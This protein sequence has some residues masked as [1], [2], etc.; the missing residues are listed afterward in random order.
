MNHQ[1]IDKNGKARYLN[2]N[3]LENLRRG[4]E[5][6]D[7]GKVRRNYTLL[8]ETV[9]WLKEQRNASDAIDRLVTRERQMN[10]IGGGRHLAGDD[11]DA[12]AAAV[13]DDPTVTRNGKDKGAVKRAIE[14]LLARLR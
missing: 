3:S 11:L 8:P 14:A 5:A 4:S 6:R 10:A 13:M 1:I 9:E 12:A 7:R 2:P